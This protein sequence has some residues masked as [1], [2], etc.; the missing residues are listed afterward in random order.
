[1]ESYGLKA[2]A[3]IREVHYVELQRL[4]AGC[5]EGSGIRCEGRADSYR[6]ESRQRELPHRHHLGGHTKKPTAENHD[7]SSM[8]MLMTMQMWFQATTDVTLWF[9]QWKID[10]PLW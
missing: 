3:V 10:E 5:I 6:L 2:G 9:K 8:E 4:D 1:M 7:H